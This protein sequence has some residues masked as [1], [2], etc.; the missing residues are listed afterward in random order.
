MSRSKTLADPGCRRSIE[1][2]LAGLAPDAPR[3]WGKMSVHQMICH[4]SD[5]YRGVIGEKALS[6]VPWPVPHFLVKWTMLNLPWPKGAPTRPE[7]K[8]GAGGSGTPPVEFE[9]DRALLLAAI[10]RFCAAP[11]SAR[12]RHPV[13]GALT[14][15]EWLRWGYL[16]ADHH[17][18]QFGA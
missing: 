5:S 9:P 11:D 8:Q 10:E 13:A 17:L 4:L 7:M 1:Q 6:P 12:G 14:R 2:R 16:H 15:E 18:R 3:R